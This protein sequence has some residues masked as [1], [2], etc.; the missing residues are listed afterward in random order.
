MVGER[1]TYDLY[2]GLKP[3]STTEHFLLKF[4]W[5]SQ[6]EKATRILGT[7]EVLVRLVMSRATTACRRLRPRGPQTGLEIFF[8]ESTTPTT[9]QEFSLERIT[10]IG[11]EIEEAE[12]EVA[13]WQQEIAECRCEAER[14]RERIREREELVKAGQHKIEQLT[15]ESVRLKRVADELTGSQVGR[16]LLPPPVNYS[17]SG[18]GTGGSGSRRVR[19]S[20]R[21]GSHGQGKRRADADAN[22]GANPH[23]MATA[24]ADADA[25]VGQF[26]SRSPEFP[27]GAVDL[28]ACMWPRIV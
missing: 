1:T 9:G 26:A 10:E 16:L 7:R 15:A 25:I 4:W 20:S 17:G 18:D 28:G 6:A 11:Q 27:A 23:A 8:G 12:S 5:P 14:I 3:Y 21:S 24:N 22:T 2:G 19:R 13:G